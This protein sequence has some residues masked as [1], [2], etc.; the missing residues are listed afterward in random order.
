M[1]AHAAGT[2]AAGDAIWALLNLELWYRTFVDGGG[3]QTLSKPQAVAQPSH[4]AAMTA[5]A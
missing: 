4:G 1:Q 3:I 5:T 2:A